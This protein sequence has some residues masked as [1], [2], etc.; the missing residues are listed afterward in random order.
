MKREY[1]DEV[2]DKL[3][4]TIDDINESDFCWIT[5]KIGDVF[6]TFQSWVGILSSEKYLNNISDYHRKV[7]DQHDTTEQDLKRIFTNVSNVDS[8]QAK[9]AQTTREAMDGYRKYINGMSAMLSPNAEFTADAVRKSAAAIKGDLDNAKDK[10][11]SEFDKQLTMKE[12]RVAKKAAKELVGDILGLAVGIC[13]FGVGVASGDFVGAA[14]AGWKMINGVFSTGQD[15]AGLATIGIGIG[16]SKT[17]LGDNRTRY[18]AVNEADRQRQK[19][20]LASELE[21]AGLDGLANACKVINVAADAYGL[22]KGATGV[23]D[24]VKDIS[25][26]LNNDILTNGT[27]LQILV[28]E[29]VPGLLGVSHMDYGNGVVGMLQN[30]K[31]VAST[32]ESAWNIV[33]ILTDPDKS[34]TEYFLDNNDVASVGKDTQDLIDDELDALESIVQSAQSGG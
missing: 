9:S 13:K 30:Q 22:Y 26:L 5:D 34:I 29:Y 27:K 24:D 12:K 4:E 3:L 25:N 31:G 10:M 2:Y 33:D 7:L 14:A 17:S 16:L 28:S 19:K 6:L 11:N 1:T 21:E 32:V 18:R 8:S 23:V 20:G 15:L